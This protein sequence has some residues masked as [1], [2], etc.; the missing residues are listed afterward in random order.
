MGDR[1][2]TGSRLTAALDQVFAR[3]PF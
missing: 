3:S 1:L 2:G